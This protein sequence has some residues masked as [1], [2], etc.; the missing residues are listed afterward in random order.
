MSVQKWPRSWDLTKAD[1]AC[2]PESW[3][4]REVGLAP[5]DLPRMSL[6]EGGPETTAPLE[7]VGWFWEAGVFTGF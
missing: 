7:P 6:T 1:K 2:V 3:P 4:Q 5:R